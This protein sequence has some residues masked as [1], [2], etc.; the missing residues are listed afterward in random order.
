[1]HDIETADVPAAGEVSVL[2]ERVDNVAKHVGYRADPLIRDKG[3]TLY[4]RVQELERQVADLTAEVAAVK[5]EKVNEIAKA[6]ERMHEAMQRRPHPDNPGT[7]ADRTVPLDQL[8]KPRFWFC[9]GGSVVRNVTA[10]QDVA[11]DRP[12]SDQTG[13]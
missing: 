12:A 11:G 6:W 10:F 3:K 7:T 9:A 13:C 4:E 5:G 1:M 8:G 2:R